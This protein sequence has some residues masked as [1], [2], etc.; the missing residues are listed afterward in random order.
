MSESQGEAHRPREEPTSV[1][2]RDLLAEGYSKIAGCDEA[3]RGP[4]AGP[5]VAAAVV[6]P[7]DLEPHLVHG[8]RDSKQLSEHQREHFYR[9]IVDLA[10]CYNVGVASPKEIDE[11]NILQAS[12]LA[13]KRAVQRLQPQPDYVLVDGNKVPA[14]ES[15]PVEAIV[16]GDR[17]SVSI[18]AASIVAKVVRDRMMVSYHQRY[19]Q[20]G[21]DSDKGYPTP[22]HRA[23]LEVFGATEIH[24][25]S[26][27]GVADH[28]L[29]S[30]PSPAFRDL[31]KRF[32]AR[33]TLERLE[34][35]QQDIERGRGRMSEAEHF[36]LR[37]RCSH[38]LEELKNRAIDL[39]PS[40]RERGEAKEEFA[41]RYLEAQ[42]YK[43][44]ERNFRLRRGEIDIIAN[45]K[46][47]VIFVEVKMRSSEAYGQPFEA[48]TKRKQ[49]TLARI[50]ET[51]MVQ[52]GLQ[53]GWDV[54]FDVI[55]ILERE[56]RSPQLEHFEDAFRPE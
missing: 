32:A 23:A 14:L 18:A 47:Q 37:Y 3:G 29:A 1:R 26:F 11:I 48:V 43:I 40:S 51:Y 19:P 50:A 39:R 7:N 4:L 36:V 46:D 8:L 35:L 27:A 13:M 44:W 38:L 30:T 10:V 9:M 16:G 45:H 12:L 28:L 49:Q 33:L 2:E 56:G 52:R 22:Y 17:R 42:G 24:R 54:R 25:H 15:I 34:K 55:S 5:V 6:L 53:T 21:F 20:Y 41:A 31:Y